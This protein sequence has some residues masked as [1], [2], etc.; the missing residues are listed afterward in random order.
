MNMCGKHH[1]IS[2]DDKEMIVVADPH[3]ESVADDV[4]G[5]IQ[6]V[7]T[8]D[9]ARHVLMFL[10]DLFHV[11]TEF[12][13]YHTPGQKA[14]LNELNAF[15]E[16]G[17][18]VFLTVGNRD[19][20]FEDRSDSPGGNGLPFDAVS[21]NFLS[22][23]SGGD[24][25]LAHHGDTVNRKDNAYLWWRRIVRSSLLKA[26][27]KLIPAERGRKL[28]YAS[29]KKIKQTNKQFRIY[30]PEDDWSRFLQAHHQK[31]APRLLLVGHFHTERP[32]VTK[33]GSTTGIVVPSWHMTQAYL[34][35]DSGL[36]YRMKRF[37]NDA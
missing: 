23:S 20:F 24:I 17:G 34:V 32:V 19:L 12:K 8:L 14:L 31:S 2:V 1:A 18:S 5:M 37:Q 7:R 22:F 25:I 16:R 10:G 13:R 27:F 29:E 4:E 33:Q 6:F 9:P 28:I 30:F 36:R 26:I 11:W 35:I 3:L 15:R 21:R